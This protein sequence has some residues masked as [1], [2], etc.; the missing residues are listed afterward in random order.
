MKVGG[1]RLII[2]S[3]ARR[4]DKRYEDRSSE[5]GAYSSYNVRILKSKKDVGDKPKSRFKVQSG[6]IGTFSVLLTSP[7]KR[8]GSQTNGIR[9]IC[10]A[11]LYFDSEV[12]S[13][14]ATTVAIYPRY[15]VSTLTYH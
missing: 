7:S 10:A 12:T 11:N 5:R 15:L 9:S 6:K 3:G 4:G 1:R 14:R 8:L 2:S 13:F